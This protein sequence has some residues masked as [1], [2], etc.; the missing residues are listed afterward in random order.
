MGFGGKK[1]KMGEGKLWVRVKWL[2]E[3][4]EGSLIVRYKSFQVFKVNEKFFQG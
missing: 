4:G 3:S 2:K 1:K